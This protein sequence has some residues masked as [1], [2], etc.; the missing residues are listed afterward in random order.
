MM[1]KNSS[2][3]KIL[4]ALQSKKSL[5]KT[6]SILKC[7]ARNWNYHSH[8]MYKNEYDFTRQ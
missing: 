8:A 3:K 7:L 5:D 4:Q 1:V 2:F 6:I